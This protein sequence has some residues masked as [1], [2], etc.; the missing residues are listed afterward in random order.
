MKTCPVCNRQHDRK[1]EY[2]LDKCRQA[3]YRKRRNAVTL[4]LK[5]HDCILSENCPQI[6]QKGSRKC[7]ERKRN[8]RNATVTPTVTRPPEETSPITPGTSNRNTIENILDTTNH[9]FFYYCNYKG[10]IS[11]G[12]KLQKKGWYKLNYN[13]FKNI[14]P[15]VNSNLQLHDKTRWNTEAIHRSKLKGP[16]ISILI[17]DTTIA[18]G[19]DHIDWPSVE[20]MEADAYTLSRIL[21]NELNIE[22]YNLRREKKR[23]IEAHVTQPDKNVEIHQEEGI[24]NFRGEMYNQGFFTL[25][26]LGKI[27]HERETD[28]QRHAALN[29]FLGDPK[30]EGPE[31]T[32][33]MAYD[34][35]EFRR[36]LGANTKLLTQL[37][38]A[39]EIFATAME[40]HHGMILDI[41]E[42]AQSQ[43]ETN[44]AMHKIIDT[45]IGK[46]RPQPCRDSAQAEI[47]KIFK[48][49]I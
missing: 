6:I 17:T 27:Q 29:D 21:E 38:Q 42:V 4:R 36:H 26:H 14:L 11:K 23:D 28:A 8:N 15:A 30:T 7:I 39:H 24:G 25:S 33:N 37:I 31:A 13:D 47:K 46:Q 5:C 10:D 1:G 18:F 20:A 43:K 35:T 44:E 9:R 3:A 12:K 2:C 22:V 49:I 45:F 41:R 16:K 48:D 19:V 40:Q 34:S 32:S